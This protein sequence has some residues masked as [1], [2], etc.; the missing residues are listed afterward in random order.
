MNKAGFLKEY[1][2]LRKKFPFTNVVQYGNENCEY[3]D[4]VFV[5]SKDCYYVFSSASMIDCLYCEDGF[6]EENDVDCRFGLNG[7]GNCECIDFAD[8]SDCY[9]SNSIA[10]CYNV[11]YSWYLEDCH[12][13]FGCANL[14]NKAYCIFNVQYTKEEYLAKLPELRK[15]PRK[16][17]LKK[18]G[19]VIR[20]FPQA[21]AEFV[22]T[23]NSEYCD[24]AY[25]M[26]N[27]YYCFDC[28]QDE[29]SGYLVTTYESKDTWDCEYV[30]R[31]EQNLECVNSGDL[32]NCYKV[33]DSS[34]CTDCCFLEDCNDCHD[35]FGCV[36]LNHKA[37]CILNVQYSKKE[38][39][40]KLKEIKKEVFSV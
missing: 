37:Y 26:T 4:N 9:Y 1:K 8:T 21:N 11:W 22:D 20:K 35:C 33:N 13:C 15:L 30:V 17:V 28:A 7:S 38:Y 6:K 27:C 16:E 10:R 36:K 12:D 31:G 5:G 40:E 34:R 39:F 23:T 24:Y 18:R 32:Y 3:T 19:E 29:D 25:N 2:E 14:S